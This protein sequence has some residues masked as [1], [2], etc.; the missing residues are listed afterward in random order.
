[1]IERVNAYGVC[2][3]ALADVMDV[4]IAARLRVSATARRVAAAYGDGC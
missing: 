1:M 4:C 3:H 2:R